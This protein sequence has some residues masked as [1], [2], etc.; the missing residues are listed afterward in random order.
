MDPPSVVAFQ[1]G[2]CSVYNAISHLCKTELCTTNNEVH[3]ASPR[4]DSFPSFVF[5]SQ[6]VFQGKLSIPRYIMHEHSLSNVGYIDVTMQRI[7]RAHKSG[8]GKETDAVHFFKPG[9]YVSVRS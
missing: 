8:I 1:L 5:A 9:F 2:D 4:V 6:T 3:F 7:V